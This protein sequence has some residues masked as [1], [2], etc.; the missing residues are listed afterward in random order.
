MMRRLLFSNNISRQIGT[1]MTSTASQK[2]SGKVAI[3]TASTDG[4]GYAIAERLGQDGAKVV[5]SSR[6]QKN[7]DAAIEK[8]RAKN[9]DVYGTVC[10]VGKKED[11][12]S[13]IQQTLDRYGGIDIMV[14]N[15][16]VNPFFGPILNC[17]EDQWDKI[18]ELNVKATFMMIKETVPHIQNRGGGSIVVVSSIAGFTPFPMLGPYSVSKTALLGLIKALVPQ[19]STMNIRINGLAPGIIDTYFS[20]A[21]T[22]NE[23]VA[24]S[25]L[26]S[27]PLNRFGQPPECAGIVSFLSSD[28]A[29]YITGETMMVTG[30]IQARL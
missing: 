12:A 19:L 3:V 20:K 15:A 8:L 10:H 6:K 5:V 24:K 7:V 26:A 25:M 16:A 29:S 17:S 23:A 14:S 2:L 21:L 9:L 22:S 18:F 28:D 1:R 27:V 4:I 30:G 11:R 13:L